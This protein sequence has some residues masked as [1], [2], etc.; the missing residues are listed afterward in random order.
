MPRYKSLLVPFNWEKA[1]RARKCYHNPNH[2]V[3][4]GDLVLEVKVQLSQ[5]G[6]CE[7]CGR[8]MIRLGLETLQGAFDEISQDEST[9]TTGS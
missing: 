4:K 5:H 3:Q 9:Q 2:Q 7:E 8:E 1:G 6:Y